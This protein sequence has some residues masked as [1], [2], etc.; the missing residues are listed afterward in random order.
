M[1]CEGFRQEVFCVLIMKKVLFCEVDN[2]RKRPEGKLTYLSRYLSNKNLN[3]C[4]YGLER[5]F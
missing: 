2:E 1:P 3:K 4:L 5:H